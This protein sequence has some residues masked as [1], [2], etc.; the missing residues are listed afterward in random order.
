[1]KKNLL[2]TLILLAGC[3]T[4]WAADGKKESNPFEPVLKD[5]GLLRQ[6]LNVNLLDTVVFDLSQAVFSGNHV[7]IPV[8]I[9]SD[10]TVYALDFSLQFNH[11]NLQYDSVI[12][13]TNYLQAYSFYN[14]GDS[15]LRFTSNSFQ[16]YTTDTSLVSIR[17]T[18]LTGQIH[19]TDFFDV[20]SYLNGDSC[21]NKLVNILTTQVTE[22]NDD[23]ISFSVYPSPSNGTLYIESN[24]NASVQLIDVEGRPVTTCIQ[25]LRNQ[26]KEINT[27]NISNGIYL[28]K[29]ISE[30]STSS[31]RILIC[32]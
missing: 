13:H 8:S 7:D 4:A 23:V 28:L 26:K 24:Q 14:T 22:I 5:N 11:T 21:S 17:F 18:M 32:N 6:A 3:I 15:T 10:D 16:S 27:Q 12:D 1:M 9:L 20:H 25:V 29:I 30:N 2:L 31:K 19:I